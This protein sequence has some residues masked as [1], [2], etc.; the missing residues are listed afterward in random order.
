[1]TRKTRVYIHAGASCVLYM[2]SDT[3]YNQ[4]PKRVQG[5]EAKTNCFFTQ[6]CIADPTGWLGCSAGAVAGVQTRPVGG[7]PKALSQTA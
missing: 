3:V 1:V 4:R 6:R 7:P 2:A 5:L